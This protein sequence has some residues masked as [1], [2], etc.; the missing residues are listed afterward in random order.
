MS[1]YRLGSDLS[2]T[3]VSRRTVSVLFVA[4]LVGFLA[5]AFGFDHEP[6][7]AVER[8]TAEWVAASM[9]SWAEWL[10][11]PP[12]W[13]GGWIGVTALALVVCVVLV[14]ER[15]WLDLAFFLTAVVGSQI[16][17]T[18]L[19]AGFERPRPDLGSVVP[20]PS[21]VLPWVREQKDT[22]P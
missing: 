11:R 9:P 22:Q 3:P 6:L 14:R 10:A 1:P 5:L 19:K 2:Q 20:L 16:V 12:S 8:E 21:T 13:L 15:A 7:A 17:V 18:L 4:G